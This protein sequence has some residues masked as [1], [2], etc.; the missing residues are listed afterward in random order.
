MVFEMFHRPLYFTQKQTV[1]LEMPR[2]TSRSAGD[3]PRHDR[4]IFSYPQFCGAASANGKIKRD[5]RGAG[6]GIKK[7]KSS[8]GFQSDF[9]P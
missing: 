9:D 7:K 4:K 5:E 3:H 2:P 8:L 6:S 1:N